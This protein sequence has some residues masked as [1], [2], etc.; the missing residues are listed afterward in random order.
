VPFICTAT[1]LSTKGPPFKSEA[2]ASHITG[3]ERQQQA[4]QAQQ[5]QV[6]GAGVL[7]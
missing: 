2:L 5:Q 3:Q 1:S 7:E 6:V 4:Q